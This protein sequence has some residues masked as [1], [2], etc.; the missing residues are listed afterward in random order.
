[1]SSKLTNAEV[2][3]QAAVLGAFNQVL[4]DSEEQSQ[5]VADALA[6]RLDGLADPAD[7][8]W[9][10]E[11]IE[12]GG[13]AFLRTRRGVTERQVIDGA[14]LRSSEARRLDEMTSDFQLLYARPANLLARG[15]EQRITG[16]IEL[17]DA[18]LALGRKGIS[19]QRYKGLGEMN[20]EQL[21]ETTLDPNVRT[22]LKVRIEHGDQAEDVFSTLMGDVV[23]PRR[24]FIQDNAQK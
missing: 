15:F 7:R 12:G 18:V 19:V 17:F 6:R 10:A 11:I 5:L 9:V 21:W 3:E 22:L 13:I 8:G 16:P 2:A 14:L 20:P 4:L 24:D 23:E 1:M